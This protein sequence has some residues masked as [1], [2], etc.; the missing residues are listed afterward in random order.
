MNLKNLE[1]RFLI[2]NQRYWL[3]ES[4]IS[5]EQCELI[6]KEADW[7]KKETA[8]YMVGKDSEVN[9]SI[10]KTT[11]TF[12]PFH[13]V[14]G[15]I[16]NTHLLEINKYQWNYDIRGIQDI[17]IGHY[18]IGGHYDWH[19][20]TMPPDENN[21]QRKLS[22]VLMLSDPNDYEGG[23]LE[24]K[25]VELPKLAQGTVIIFPSPMYHRVTELTKGERYTAVAWAVGPAFR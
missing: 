21:M 23:L 24:I 16:M 20:D 12:M 15:C 6:I 5:K 7:L 22:A 19:P 2:I 8:E 25:D 10:R 14:V 9:N 13:S 1:G 3:Y 18:G 11:V 4:A 17:Q